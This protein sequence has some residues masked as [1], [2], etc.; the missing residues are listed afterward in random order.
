MIHVNLRNLQ[1]EQEAELTIPASYRSRK[2]I[3]AQMI[4]GDPIE[5]VSA[6]T[7]LQWLDKHLLGK[8]IISAQSID[9][10]GF[11]SRRIEGQTEKEKRI[12][13]AALEIEKPHTLM[14]IVNLSC[15][16][17]KF[18][19]YPNVTDEAAL[20]RCL[21]EKRKITVSEELEPYIDYEKGGHQYAADHAGLFNN[22][23]Y[24]VR[25]GEALQ[26]IYDGQRLPNPAYE[27]GWVFLV[28]LNLPSYMK[29][30]GFDYPLSLPASDEKLAIARENLGVQ[31]LEDCRND[32]TECSVNGLISYLPPGFRLEELNEFAKQLRSQI[33]D[34]T[35]ETR[36]KLLAALEAECPRDME[37][38]AEIAANLNRYDFQAEKK[39]L[40]PIDYA[41]YVIE[42]QG[43]FIADEV[44]GYIDYEA[45]GRSW[46]KEDGVIQTDFG[47]IRRTDRP[48][49]PLQ[50]EPE[51]TRLFS[52][53][54]AKLYTREE[55][56]YS[57]T[58][59]EISAYEL[60]EHEGAIL[61][62]IQQE[63]LEDEGERGLAVYL[64]NQLLKRRVISMNPTVEI[65]QGE[66]WGVLEVQ[67]RGNLTDAELEAVKKEWCGQE[68][69]GWG[70]GFEQRPIETED[71]ELFV[72]FWNPGSSFFITT[73]Q[74]LKQ[75][76][77]QSF[78]MQMGGM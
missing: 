43:V 24:A 53:L 26:P 77:E 8:T 50:E 37:A 21:M 47:M 17:D 58:P 44:E 9:E 28:H 74:N 57:D 78:G 59:V 12:F 2:E 15:N 29:N 5:I 72:S 42:Y 18:E 22:Y 6:E 34:G 49:Q 11:I 3:S 35:E 76:S 63:K 20:G 39:T 55:W 32:Y 14:E 73:E 69:D 54:N 38:V 25:T 48:I 66:L 16:L 13:E 52:P 45:M 4:N 27:K 31:R 23:G 1:K 10:L 7:Q 65:W 36:V 30:N 33:L 56:G 41:N 51:T 75:P 61:E 68:S 67:S 40:S 71:G 64:D 60:C 62:M 19:L 70:E 46:L